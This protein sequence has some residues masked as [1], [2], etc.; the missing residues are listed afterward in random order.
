[1]PSPRTKPS[2]TSLVAFFLFVLP[3]VYVLSYAPVFRFT[4]DP[5]TGFF[6]S[7]KGWQEPYQPVEWLTDNTPLR[8]PLLFW[9][10]LWGTVVEADFRYRSDRRIEGEDPYPDPDPWPG[11]GFW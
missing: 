6:G 9:A 1:M 8:E 5:G 10:G 4:G 3:L 11:N 7:R 2:L